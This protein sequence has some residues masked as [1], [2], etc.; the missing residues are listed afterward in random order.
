MKTEEKRDEATTAEGA[1]GFVPSLAVFHCRWCQPDSDH[2]R[3]MLPAEVAE[4]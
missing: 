3:E 1:D 2:V 4:R